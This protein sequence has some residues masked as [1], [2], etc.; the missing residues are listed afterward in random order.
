MKKIDYYFD[1]L[2]PYSYF[3]F[4]NLKERNFFSTYDIELKP[5]SMGSLFNH[6]DMKGPGMIKPKRHYMLKQ[7]FIYSAMKKVPFN[8]PNAH[9]FNPLYALRLATK[10][11]SQSKESQI[12][13]VEALFTACWAQ[14]KGL[15]DPGELGNILA[16]HGLSVELLDKTFDKEVKKELKQNIKDAISANIFGV[17]SFQVE[18]QIFW[19]NDSIELLELY[20]N[21][22]FPKWNK[23]LFETKTS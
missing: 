22:Q 15:G 20:I 11:C 14:G 17:P 9:P 18:D 5:V 1:F 2:S 16:E 13:L 6:F 4:I 7:C 21:N 3:S 8:P 10:A 19:G 12:K 23:S